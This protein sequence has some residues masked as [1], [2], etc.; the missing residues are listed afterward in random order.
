MST[1]QIERER[2]ARIT[3]N[4]QKLA[5]LGLVQL[6]QQLFPQATKQ[7]RVRTLTAPAVSEPRRSGRNKQIDQPTTM[8]SDSEQEAPAGEPCSPMTLQYKTSLRQ[9]YGA[10]Q[11]PTEEVKRVKSILVDSDVG[12]DQVAD[13]EGPDLQEL[14]L[15][16]GL[17]LRFK[18][19]R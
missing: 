17:K 9:A 15:S 4:Q 2:R 10:E 19:R 11:W 3:Q 16:L 14:G 1:P 7:Q 8:P 6:G 5:E 13:L 12:P 18:K